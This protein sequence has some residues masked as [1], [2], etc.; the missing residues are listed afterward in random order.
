VTASA[1]SSHPIA[2]DFYA[3]EVHPFGRYEVAIAALILIFLYVLIILEIVHRYVAGGRR[4][5]GEERGGR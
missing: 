3:Y 1:N 4:E 5:E 2:I